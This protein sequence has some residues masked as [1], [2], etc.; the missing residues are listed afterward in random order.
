MLGITE[1]NRLG[2]NHT[3]RLVELSYLEYIFREIEPIKL[4]YWPIIELFVDFII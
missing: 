1:A 2:P 4:A 3:Y